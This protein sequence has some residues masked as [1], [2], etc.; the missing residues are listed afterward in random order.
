MHPPGAFSGGQRI[1]CSVADRFSAHV[2]NRLGSVD[3]VHKLDAVQGGGSGRRIRASAAQPGGLTWVYPRASLA[4]L[5]VRAAMITAVYH[6]QTFRLCESEREKLRRSGMMSRSGVPTT[7][8]SPRT[9][10][11]QSSTASNLTIDVPIGFGRSGGCNENVPLGTLS[12]RAHCRARS[13][14]EQVQPTDHFGLRVS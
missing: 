5:P 12:R 4:P 13:S 9:K 10:S 3:H 14:P 2:G 1:N 6:E 8:S 11:V 7:Q